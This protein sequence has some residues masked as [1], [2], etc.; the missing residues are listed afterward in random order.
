MSG[1][2]CERK[3]PG[4]QLCRAA[5]RFT[6]DTIGRV[7]TSCPKCDRTAAGFCRDCPR[8][9]EGK[10]RWCVDCKRVRRRASEQRLMA[11]PAKRARR[12]ARARKRSKTTAARAKKRESRRAWRLANPDKVKRHKRREALK[13]LPSYI[14]NYTRWNADPERQEKKRAAAREKYYAEHPTPPTPHCAGCG[15]RLPYAPRGLGGK[16]GAPP[17]WCDS[18]APAPEKARRRKLGRSIQVIDQERAA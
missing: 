9:I 4:R 12:L 15:G 1:A 17:K 8:R 16:Q 5:L 13:R 2:T 11:D 14:A 7:S 3:L 18:C 10:H 6:S